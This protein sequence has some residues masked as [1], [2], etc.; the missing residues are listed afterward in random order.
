MG[1]LDARADRG[2]LPLVHALAKQTD[3]R[4]AG[5]QRFEGDRRREV[6]ILAAVLAGQVAAPRHYQVRQNRMIRRG[7]RPRDYQDLAH[8][9]P[10]GFR[11]T[12]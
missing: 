10:D 4:F 9:P 8:T 3:A 6:V 11:A 12:P 1:V 7:Q 2:P 5:G